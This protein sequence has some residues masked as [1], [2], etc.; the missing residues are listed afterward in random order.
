MNF[1]IPFNEHDSLRLSIAY[2]VTDLK[3]TDLTSQEVLDFITSNGN[4][5]DT[6][7]LGVGWA[8]DT[9]NRAI[10]ADRGVLHSLSAEVALPG[11][12]LQY[13]KLSYRQQR[14]IPLS[15]NLTFLMKG[16]IAYGEGYGD[17]RSLPFYENFF[18]GGARSVRGYKDNSLYSTAD[19]LD[20]KGE[21]LGGNLK[22]VGSAEL[23]FPVPFAPEAKSVRL[24]AFF[25]AG[26]IFSGID[27]FAIG[28]IRG[29]A[30]L[31][32]RWLSPVGPLSFSLATP[33]NDQPGDET[34][35]FQ[36][37]LGGSF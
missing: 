6:F 5:F 17:T 27:K 35:V 12:D 25:D 31:S 4:N 37:S 15:K 20:S 21:P 2:A 36:F 16:E 19:T 30:G 33:I 23:I 11:G 10:F 13:Y 9:R 1:G 29:S 7:T 8:H 3:T 24:S 28:Q 34:Q 14:Y 22:T 26:N 18:A 32:L